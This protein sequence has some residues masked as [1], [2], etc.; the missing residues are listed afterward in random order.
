M[1]SEILCI[2]NYLGE[3]EKSFLEKGDK[4][5]INVC[6]KFYGANIDKIS[7]YIWTLHIMDDFEDNI[8]KLCKDMDNI[9]IIAQQ[10][11]KLLKEDRKKMIIYAYLKGNIS[12]YNDYVSVKKIRSMYMKMPNYKIEKISKK[13]I[14]KYEEI[15]RYIEIIKYSDINKEN[16]K[17]LTESMEN[18]YLKT[19]KQYLLDTNFNCDN[20]RLI[21][22]IKELMRKDTTNKYNE[23][24]LD[25]IIHKI[26]KKSCKNDKMN[27]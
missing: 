1:V 27:L 14:E 2:N 15:N 9:E 3:I 16:I 13:N 11:Y 12:G 7:I 20:N 8:K 23:G 10:I 21:D 17:L 6:K 18:H 22:S 19:V 24:I 5:Y 4:K 26:N 25:G